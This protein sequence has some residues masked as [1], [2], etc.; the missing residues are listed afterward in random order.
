MAAAKLI[1]APRLWLYQ[2]TPP[3]CRFEENKLRGIN[4]VA[5][6]PTESNVS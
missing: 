2:T 4:M 5:A 3:Q 6:T 1:S